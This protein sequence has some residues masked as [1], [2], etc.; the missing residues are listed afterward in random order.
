[1]AVKAGVTLADRFVDNVTL[2]ENGCWQWARPNPQ[3]GYGYL[4]V[5]GTLKLAHVIGWELFRGPVP[6]D[7]LEFDHLCCNTSCVNP[8][9]LER[10]THSENVRRAWTHRERATRCP[11]GHAYTP[12]NTGRHPNG[13]PRCR[14]CARAYYHRKKA[15]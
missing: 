3:R 5:R 2:L 15:S 13:S 14:A 8:W 6:D 4:S 12:E 11:Q 7:G 9:H 1:M 10:V